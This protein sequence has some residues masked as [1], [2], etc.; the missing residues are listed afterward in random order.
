MLQAI[1]KVGEMDTKDLRYKCWLK[2]SDIEFVKYKLHLL[3][4]QG[5]IFYEFSENKICNN[6][7]NRRNYRFAKMFSDNTHT[8]RSYG[9]VPG[10]AVQKVDH[11]VGVEKDL[12]HLTMPL[13]RSASTSFFPVL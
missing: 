13:N 4:M 12:F 6:E 3:F 8:I 7:S 1:F 2:R 10:S 9:M 5:F 11:N